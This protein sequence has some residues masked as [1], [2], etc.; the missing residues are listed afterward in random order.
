MKNCT[1][2]TLDDLDKALWMIR[3]E[4]DEHGPRMVVVKSAKESLHEQQRRLYWVWVGHVVEYTGDTDLEFHERYKIEVFFPIY[5]KDP[6]NHADLINAVEAM[7][8]IR[9][10]INP[11]HYETIKRC[12]LKECSSLNATVQNMREVLKQLESDANSLGV[13]L[14]APPSLELME[15]KQ[16]AIK[17]KEK[18]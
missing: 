13:K 16:K 3:D 18:V 14:P 11:K 10:S 5:M 2:S 17:A 4:F 8:N 15:E 6:D 1:V 7:K 9:Q 12:V